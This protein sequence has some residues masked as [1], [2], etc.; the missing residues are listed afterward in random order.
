MDHKFKRNEN[1]QLNYNNYF[2]YSSFR[3]I[4]FIK[5]VL[6]TRFEPTTYLMTHPMTYN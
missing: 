2:V 1:T 5:I 3:G 4:S 6:P